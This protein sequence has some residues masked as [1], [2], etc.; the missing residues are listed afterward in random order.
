MAKEKWEVVFEDEDETIIW[1][2]DMK[3]NKSGPS[4]VEI[5]Q[6]SKSKIKEKK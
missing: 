5:K 1:R 3:K 4:E 6:K 2:Y